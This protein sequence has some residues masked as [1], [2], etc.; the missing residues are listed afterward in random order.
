MSVSTP[1]TSSSSG[2]KPQLSFWQIWN[3]SFGFLGIQF[4]WA[5]Q[6]ANMSAIYEFLGAKPDEIPMLWLAA[7]LTGLLVQP[8]IGY[9]SDRTWSSRYGRRKPYFLIGAILASIALFLMPSSSTLWMAAGLLWILD[10]SINISM[11]PFR[12]FV[13]DMLPEEQHTKGFTMQSM[14]IGLGAVIASALPYILTNYVGLGGLDDCSGVSAIPMSVKISFFIGAAAFITAVVYTVSTTKEYPPV[15]MDRFKKEKEEKRGFAVGVSEIL[16]SIRNMPVTM[17]QLALVQ[18]LTW[19][20]L[21]LMWFYFGVAITRTVFHYDDGLSKYEPYYRQYKCSAKEGETIDFPRLVSLTNVKEADR[22]SAEAM[23]QEFQTPQQFVSA[24]GENVKRR[25]DGNEWGG[26]CFA[27]YSLVT[28]LV[29]FLL[30]VIADRTSKRATHALCLSIGALGLFSVGFIHDQ[31]LLLLSMTG[32]GIA[33]ASILSMPYAML[34]PVLPPEKTG[35]YM[36]IFNFFIVL[37]EILATLGF[38]WIMEHLLHNN[39]VAAV[40]VGGALLA[41]AAFLC[42][43]IREKKPS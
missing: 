43:F 29:A 24:V 23:T 20:G 8:V 34:A 40:T 1:G 31:Y 33:W 17:R 4:G 36:G 35:I 16:K 5:L 14:F 30:P 38:G 15:D 18:F 10:A 19:P 39:R 2:L 26:I 7:P 42:L 11:E 13:A 25:S 22:V 3:M 41:I 28:F 27:F 12:A 37:P 21:F 9:M 6:M 32:V